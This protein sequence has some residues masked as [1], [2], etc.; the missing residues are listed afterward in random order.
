MSTMCLFNQC[1]H[2]AIPGT[3]KCAF[4]RHR[5][6]CSFPNCNNQVV[7]NKLCVRHG[8]KRLCHADGCNHHARGGKWCLRHGGVTHKRFCTAPGCEKQAHANKKCIA[9]G[10]GRRCQ[11]QGCTFFARSGGHCHHHLVYSATPGDS[12]TDFI[13]Q[14]ILDLVVDSTTCS[15]PFDD[16][17]DLSIGSTTEDDLLLSQF[18]L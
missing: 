9:H 14:L 16:L 15:F 12:T 10:G 1:P 8:G 18:V 17:K 6:K 3:S 2:E 13:D 11:V 7:V 5:N 4:H